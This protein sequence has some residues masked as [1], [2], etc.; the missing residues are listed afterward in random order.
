MK[1]IYNATALAA[2]LLSSLTSSADEGGRLSFFDKE[3]FDFEASAGVNIG[4]A[5]P[6][7]LPREIRKIESYNPNLNLQI[8]ASVTRWFTPSKKW[9]ITIGANMQ[10]KGMETMANVKN[11][12]M[13]IIQDGKKLSG[14]WTGKVHTRYHS[15]QLAIPIQGVYSIN[16][17]FSVSLGPYLAYAFQ[18][19]FDGYV[20]EGYLREG[21]P[22]GDK[23]TFDADSRAT[24]DFGENLRKFHWGMQGGISW[25]AFRHFNVKANL[26]WGANGIFEKS[27]KTV[28]FT[29]YPIYLNLG[30]GYRF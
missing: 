14:R 17:K 4:G 24:Y 11:Y 27:F 25:A 18:N 20:T 7:P 8:G 5:A 1:K 26:M 9:G 13:E 23:V 21:D 10:T 16:S 29:L 6:I 19:D 15:Q 22:T 2:M 3:L 30:F 12:G 28:S